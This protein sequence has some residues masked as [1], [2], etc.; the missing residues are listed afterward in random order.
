MLL[1]L[2]DG[3]VPA[4]PRTRMSSTKP[5]SS[6]ADTLKAVEVDFGRAAG[7]AGGG[8]DTLSD[9]VQAVGSACAG[10]G[11]GGGVEGGSSFGTGQPQ[12]G[13]ASARLLTS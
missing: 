2:L 5:A 1:G 12:C 3:E 13:H 8:A 4:Q 7:L 10:G 9:S 6:S 11:T